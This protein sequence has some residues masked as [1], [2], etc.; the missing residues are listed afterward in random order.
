MKKNI[1]V[2]LLL[3]VG[4]LVGCTREN[5]LNFNE[6]F[7]TMESVNH[8]Y[9]KSTYTTSLNLILD[10]T[11]VLLV[12]YDS[13]KKV[14]N[15]TD[16]VLP[17]LNEAAIEAKQ[18]LIHYLDIYDM[19]KDESAEYRL[20]LGYLDSQVE[21]MHVLSGSKTLL[22]PDVYFIKEGQIIGHHYSTIK[23]ENGNYVSNLNA[24]QKDE[25]KEI[26]L[27]LFSKLK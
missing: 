20:L 8:V 14:D 24:A 1:L 9:K 23:D 3:V 21:D 17:I 5:D 6:S 2:V 10:G 11:G 12:A 25:L 16:A 15:Y 13:D 18:D 22:A 26:Y 4:L 27:H 7:P 19:Q